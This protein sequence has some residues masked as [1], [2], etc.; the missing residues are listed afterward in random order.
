LNESQRALV[1]ARL[2]ELRENEAV[3]RKSR[4]VAQICDEAIE[5][6]KTRG[7]RYLPAGA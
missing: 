3:K 2:A 5:A 7:F 4:L 1:A 6:L